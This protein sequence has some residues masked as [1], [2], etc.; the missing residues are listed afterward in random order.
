MFSWLA[1]IALACWR[2]VSRYARMNKDYNNSNSDELEEDSFSLRDS[3][4]W[5]RDLEKHSCGDFSFAV[6]QANEII[7]DHSQ[8]E[9]GK[10]AIFV[11]VYDGHGG[12]DAS[13]FIS[14][15]L[16]QNLITGLARANGTISE[17]ILRNAF[18]ATEDGFL[19][20]VRRSCG[21]KPLIAAIGSCCL[22]GVIWRGTLYVANLGD[23]RAVIGYLGRSNKIVAEQLT[24][25]HNA[26]I[27][28]VRQEL[29]SL[30]PD[31]SHIVVMKHG[32]WRIKGIIQVSRSIGDAYLKR[33][34]FSLD[35][36]FPR[37][38]LSEPI[39]RP[40]LTAE[41][42]LCTRV[43]QPSDKFLIF[44][45]DGLWEHLTNQ[46]AVEIVS[47]SPRAGIARRLIKTALNEAARKREM[48]Y[49]DLKKVDKGIR[50]FFHDDITVVVIFIDQESLST[51]MPVLE[52]SVKG[53]A[54]SI[55]PSNF[56]IL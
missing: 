38:H 6:V 15:H 23:S 16:F 1:R 7:E 51:K 53:F 52:Q 32:V 5:C 56:N 27:E 40:V 26:S 50:R 35:P 13:R 55:G 41:P 21:I 11:G 30:H 48:R 3:L 22:V 46:Q 43:L 31:D 4:L 34:E 8:V 39:R 19:A 18:S 29:R 14:D 17:D 20:L 2:P 25:D 10:D 9:T 42:S 44:A 28:E 49:D 24:R 37:F 45:S 12:P 47:N 33:P 54:D 36:S